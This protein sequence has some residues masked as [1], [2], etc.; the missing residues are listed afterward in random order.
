MLSKRTWTHYALQT[1]HRQ[2]ILGVHLK[3]IMYHALAVHLED[4]MCRVRC[5]AEND[6]KMLS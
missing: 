5:G 3:D 2:S 4:I 1:H 6:M